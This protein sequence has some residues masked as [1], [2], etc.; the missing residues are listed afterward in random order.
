MSRERDGP[1][2]VGFDGGGS[3]ES[4]SGSSV[5]GF[6]GTVGQGGTGHLMTEG[7]STSVGLLTLG[8]NTMKCTVFPESR[9]LLDLI[10]PLGIHISG[11]RSITFFSRFMV[12]CLFRYGCTTSYPTVVVV[13]E[14]SVLPRLT[15]LTSFKNL[16]PF[17]FLCLEREPRGLP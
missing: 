5:S 4:G 2:Q 7:V 1:V 17:T 11:P 9:T 15:V 6:T 3:S 8:P 13:T 14:T 12:H 10:G 16:G